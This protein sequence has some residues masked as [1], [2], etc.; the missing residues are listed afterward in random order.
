[1]LEL[2]HG[3]SIYTADTKFKIR[4]ENRGIGRVS[5]GARRINRIGYT[6]TVKAIK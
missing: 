6:D 5:I 1:M 4:D 3:S 2:E